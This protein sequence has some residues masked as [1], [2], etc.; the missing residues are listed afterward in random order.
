MNIED[1]APKDVSFDARPV[2]VRG[3]VS[4]TKSG[5]IYDIDIVYNKIQELFLQ[6]P[7]IITAFDVHS[8]RYGYLLEL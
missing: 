7:S 8:A 6:S 3:F 2:I 1:I 4:A 5:K